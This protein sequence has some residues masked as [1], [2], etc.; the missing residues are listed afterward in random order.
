MASLLNLLQALQPAEILNCVVAL[1][2]QQSR[3]RLRRILRQRRF[4]FL[5]QTLKSTAQA[6]IT[7][8]STEFARVGGRQSIT[9]AYRTW[10]GQWHVSWTGLKGFQRCG[11]QFR[12]GCH[13]ATD[14]G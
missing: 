13:P 9:P 14:A 6:I 7:R 3:L 2:S 8:L 10:A 4:G 1:I 12:R 11:L 5:T